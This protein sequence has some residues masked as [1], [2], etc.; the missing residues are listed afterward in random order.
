MTNVFITYELN[1]F[2]FSDSDTQYVPSMPLTAATI[3]EVQEESFNTSSHMNRSL[4]QTSPP[5]DVSFA[6]V[7]PNIS[8]VST[9]SYS[10]QP[11]KELQ[12][13]S[14][15]SPYGTLERETS[16]SSGR[17]SMH[18]ISDGVVPD[19][20][21]DTMDRGF[22]NHDTVNST[23]CM[24]SMQQT[25]SVHCTPFRKGLQLKQ[26]PP[27]DNWRPGQYLPGLDRHSYITESDDVTTVASDETEGG[28]VQFSCADISDALHSVRTK[29]HQ[30]KT[31]P[32]L[33]SIPDDD[34]ATTTT[35]GSYVVDPTDLC[36]EI[37]DLFFKDMVV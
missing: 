9:H 27:Y 24:I 17:D 12:T 6:Q 35:S 23:D 31:V 8:F 4:N 1:Q 18:N 13:F 3:Q 37:D 22:I 10:S 7:V 28:S 16:P 26:K 15:R 2:L 19:F 21:S 36:N 20:S 14:A 25:P 30:Y 11:K 32:A 29:P 34:A 33:E 5:T